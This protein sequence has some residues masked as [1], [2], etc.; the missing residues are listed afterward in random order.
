MPDTAAAAALDQGR[1]DVASVSEPDLSQAVKA[2]DRVLGYSYDAV[3]HEYLIG[4]Y[5]ATSAFAK[6]HAAELRKFA[7]AMRETALWANKNPQLSAPILTKY[8]RV[9][10]APGGMRV[11]YADKLSAAQIQPVIDASAQFHVLKSAFP[12]SEFF[13]GN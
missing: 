1:I 10:V 5:F 8:T 6:A 4:A 7:D 2:N 12:A 3:G 13:P 11:L 9:A